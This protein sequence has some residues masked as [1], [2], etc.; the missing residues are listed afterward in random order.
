MKNITKLFTDIVGKLLKKELGSTAGK[1]NLIG[2]VTVIA[3]AVLV[4]V[5]N[6]G[7]KILNAFL[8]FF[9]KPLLPAIGTIYILGF[10]AVI[11]IYFYLCVR[12]IREVDG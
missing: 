9:D 11:L 8:T 3:M 1:V 2:G 5:E 4:F 7:V 10:F 6:V 12:I